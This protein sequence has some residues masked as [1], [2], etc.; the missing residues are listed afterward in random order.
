MSTEQNKRA[1]GVKIAVGYLSHMLITFFMFAGVAYFINEIIYEKAW[2]KD[3]FIYAGALFLIIALYSAIDCRRLYSSFKTEVILIFCF[4]V[5]ALLLLQSEYY[6][7]LPVWLIGG[8]AAAALVNSNIGMLY[9]YFFVFHAIYLQGNPVNGLIFHFVCATAVCLLIPKMKTWASM[10]YMMIFSGALIVVLSIVLNRF[11]INRDVLLDAFSIMCVYFAGIFITMLFVCFLGTGNEKENEYDKTDDALVTYEY[12]EQ[13]AEE[14][15]ESDTLQQ[16]NFVAESI[17][18][19]PE[20][21]FAEECKEE[22]QEDYSP[23]CDE[24]AAVLQELKKQKK[25]VYAHAVLTGKLSYR[26]S[27]GIGLR[28][29]VAMAIALYEPVVKLWEKEADNLPGGL[30]LMI[31]ELLTGEITSKETALVAMADDVISN[32][33]VIR[34]MKKLSLAP[35]KIVDKTIEKK[36][37][38][39]EYNGSGMTLSE[40]TGLRKVFVEFLQEQDNRLK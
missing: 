10:F 40:Y 7:N 24:K 33:T 26:A 13:L 20:N 9:V 15:M 35:E 18:Q 28:S 29:E 25:A 2:S 30:V 8:I 23:Y 37:F 19:E 4:L 27:E 5:S 14:T 11:L 16:G 32:Y 22:P 38:R 17:P 6:M 3:Y 31:Q 34:H 36:M 12:L 21:S 1:S 39:G